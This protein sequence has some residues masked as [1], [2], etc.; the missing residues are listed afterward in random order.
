MMRGCLRGSV[1]RWFRAATVHGVNF[2]RYKAQVLLGLLGLAAAASPLQS[3][4]SGSP[5]S[6]ADILRDSSETLPLYPGVAPG[7]E[8]AQWREIEYQWGNEPRL[9]NVTQPMLTVFRPPAGQANG[10]AMV[11]APGG[12]F[13]FLSMKSEGA[14]VARALAQRGVT[15]LLLKYRTD[16][17]PASADAFDE[18]IRLMFSGQLKRDITAGDG[19]RW[20]TADGLAAVKL[21]REQSK[22]LGIDPQRIGLIGFSAGGMLTGRAL[23]GYD[24]ASRPDFAAIIYGA[25]P[26]G[27]KVPVDAPPLFVAVS[28]DDP[29]LGNASVPIYEAWRAAGKS[30]ELHIYASGGHG[31][32]MNQQGKSSDHWIDA[33]GWWLE[34]QGLLRAR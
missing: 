6:I 7:S 30:A 16:E 32:G 13:Q 25:L 20:A 29:L 8:Q 4:T 26:A 23:M 22:R 5:A 17:S 18:Q 2:M 14:D 15:A 9:R 11:V 28:A 19:I 31:Y 3:A 27:A 10:A 34:S 12:G 1:W 33:L 24:A 21:A